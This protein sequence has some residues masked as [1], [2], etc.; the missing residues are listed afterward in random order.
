MSEFSSART[1]QT[2]SA[3]GTWWRA[4]TGHHRSKSDTASVISRGTSN[5]SK[6]RNRL[7]VPSVISQ[8]LS[9]QRDLP[10]HPISRTNSVI[11]DIHIRFPV[12]D[13]NECAVSDTS[14]ED[15]LVQPHQHT[16]NMGDRAMPQ[17]DRTHT[18]TES[19]GERVRRV[20]RP[21]EPAPNASSST[22][23][24]EPSLFDACYELQRR[25]VR[26]TLPSLQS[27]NSLTTAITAA[28]NNTG[29]PPTSSSG[30]LNLSQT[31]ASNVSLK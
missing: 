6:T 15:T 17:P 26:V 19:R 22:L 14:A 20:A 27:L 18:N 7:S 13:T 1:H 28:T 12:E 30:R 29:P 24:T 9:Y 11:E 31:T 5:Q 3:V 23:S 16:A 2:T 25:N 8:D 4:G 21:S 10:V